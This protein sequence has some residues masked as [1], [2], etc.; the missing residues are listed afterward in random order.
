MK[1]A[2]L[3]ITAIL[4]AS[5]VSCDRDSITPETS[6]AEDRLTISDVT[7]SSFK[8]EWYFSEEADGYRCEVTYIDTESLTRSVFLGNIEGTELEFNALLPATDYKI[9]VSPRKDGVTLQH[10]LTATATTSGSDITFQITPLEKYENASYGIMPFAEVTPSDNSVYYWVSAIPEDITETADVMKW[11]SEDISGM[12]ES[13]FTWDDLISAGLILQGKAETAPFSF[14]DYGTFRFVAV[15]V[16]KNMSGIIPVQAPSFSY[17][18]WFE[19]SSQRIRHLCSLEDYLG[20]WIVKTGPQITGFYGGNFSYGENY[21]EF[22][23]TIRKSDDGKSLLIY[24]WGGEESAYSSYPVI[25]DYIEASDG[26]DSITFTSPQDITSE[27]DTRWEYVSW[28]LFNGTVSGQYVSAYGPYGKEYQDTAPAWKTGFEGYIGNRNK[29]VIK[30]FG[31]EYNDPTT[32]Y[33]GAYMT[34]IWPCGTDGNGS[35]S[36]MYGIHKE[37]A[38]PY[39]LTRKDVYDGS[40]LE[41]PPVE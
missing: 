7:S 22:P 12:T 14:Y 20:E 5:A 25:F 16:A 19:N 1:S 9:R 34:S 38:G 15:P 21:T 40:V 18:F 31:K 17:F 4:A 10:W 36:L 37:P 24:G 26:Y 27:G 6:E 29:T 2:L 11:I 13:G 32:Y 3:F 35:T 28:F 41:I 33:E 30:I 23:V 39:Y 8:A